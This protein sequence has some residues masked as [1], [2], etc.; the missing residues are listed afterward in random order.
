MRGCHTGFFGIT[1]L[2]TIA[3]LYDSYGLIT[4]LDIIENKRH[5]DKQYDP[6]DAIEIYFDQIEDAV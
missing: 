4:A 5:I 6:S 1:Y 3:H 2:Q